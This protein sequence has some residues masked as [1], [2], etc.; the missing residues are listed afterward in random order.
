MSTRILSVFVIGLMMVSAPAFAQWVT[1]YEN[2]FNDANDI[3]D[4]MTVHYTGS[5]GT[6]ALN[7]GKLYT[8]G[9]GGEYM[10][11]PSTYTAPTDTFYRVSVEAQVTEQVDMGIMGI[12]YSRINPDP[13]VHLSACDLLVINQ[14]RMW[15]YDVQGGPLG[16]N[17]MGLSGPSINAGQVYLLEM[18]RAASG[19][20]MKVDGNIVYE[21]KDY[22]L[23]ARGGHVG[24]ASH[25][26]TVEYDNFKVEVIPEPSSLL[27]L[28]PGLAGLVAFRRKRA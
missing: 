12:C 11:G 1:V 2:D 14:A 4:W 21:D 15:F 19:F 18:G 5:E 9:G 27:V 28:L 26:D 7:A 24:I 17:M 16:Q 10:V 20:Y 3:D 8:Y 25:R 13:G 22:P 6:S 23:A